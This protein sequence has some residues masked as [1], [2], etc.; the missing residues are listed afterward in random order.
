MTLLLLA[1]VMAVLSALLTGGL[2]PLAAYTQAFMMNTADFIL[3]AFPLFFLRFFL[4]S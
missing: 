3:A 1:P 2:P 4:A